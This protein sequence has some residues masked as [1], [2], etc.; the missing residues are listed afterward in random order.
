MPQIYCEISS[1][2]AKKLNLP[3]YSTF[4]SNLSENGGLSIENIFI[5]RLIHNADRSWVHDTS[6]TRYIKNKYENSKKAVVD[7]A[8]F[9]MI[10]LKSVNVNV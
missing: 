4:H 2:T 7:M 3:E 10:K 5:A 9:M 1:E 6:G 8:E